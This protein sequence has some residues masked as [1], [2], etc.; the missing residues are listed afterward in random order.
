MLE[1]MMNPEDLRLLLD[2]ATEAGLNRAW[3]IRGVRKPARIFPEPGRERWNYHLTGQ[4][5]PRGASGLLIL[6]YFPEG[7]GGEPGIEEL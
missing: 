3:V 7:D 2:V 4:I 5:D 1:G 6:L